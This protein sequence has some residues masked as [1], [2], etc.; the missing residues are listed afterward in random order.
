MLG[1]NSSQSPR[2]GSPPRGVKRVKL[3]FAAERLVSSLDNFL[4]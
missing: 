1:L 4:S 3:G 2:K